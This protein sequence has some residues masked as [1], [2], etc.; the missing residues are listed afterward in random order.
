MPLLFRI[1]QELPAVKFRVAGMPERDADQSTLDA[2]NGLRHLPNVEL[3]GHVGEALAP[4]PPDR[5]AQLGGEG[6][7]DQDVVVDRGD[8]AAHS[9]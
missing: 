9:S 7:G 5:L 6:L 2:V 3:V 4:A 8:V 1:A